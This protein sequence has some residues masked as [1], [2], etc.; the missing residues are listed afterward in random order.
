M[1]SWAVSTDDRRGG[2][3]LSSRGKQ[4]TAWQNRTLA[5][6][7]WGGLP[8]DR[9]GVIDWHGQEQL[10]PPH[11]TYWCCSS[12]CEGTHQ[13]K[14]NSTLLSSITLPGNCEDFFVPYSERQASLQI[15]VSRSLTSQQYNPWSSTTKSSQ[16]TLYLRRYHGTCLC[17]SMLSGLLGCSVGL[18]KTCQVRKRES[19][20]WVQDS[21]SPEYPS[22]L[23]PLPRAIP[24]QRSEGEWGNA[25]CFLF[26]LFTTACPLMVL[27][28]SSGTTWF[29]IFIFCYSPWSQKAWHSI[30]GVLCS[31]RPWDSEKKNHL[32]P[33]T[34]TELPTVCLF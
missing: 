11:A 6:L 4:S 7:V 25:L 20:I 21:L 32:F 14:L 33:L 29:F 26:S 19:R 10:A 1:V 27:V 16:L 28:L 12:C 2:G 24:L 13:I 3:S 5:S 8:G 34:P 15:L 23:P 31:L 9:K 17:S 22:L 18:S 30:P